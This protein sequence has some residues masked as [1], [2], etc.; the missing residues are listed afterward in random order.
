MLG[1]SEHPFARRDTMAAKLSTERGTL[2][3][4]A[5][6]DLVKSLNFLDGFIPARG[7][8][9]RSDQ[10]LTRVLAVEGQAVVYSLTPTGSVD[11]PRLDYTLM[12]AAPLS[13]EAREAALDRIR[14]FLSL[15]DDLTPL[16][17]RAAEDPVFAP[18]AR[19]LY[20]YHQVL[21]GSPFEAA[22][23][24][25]LSQR[26]L[27]TLSQRMKTALIDE[28]GARLVVDGHDYRAFPEPDILAHAAPEMLGALINHR[29]KGALLPGVAWAFA[30]MDE[31]WL[32]DAPFAE[33]AAWLK[34]I[35][36]IGEWSASFILL[37]G[38]GRVE[39]LPAQEKR[40]Q[41]VVAKRYGLVSA[42]MADVKRL[43]APYGNV[44]GYWAH[45]LRVAD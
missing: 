28:F 38:L 40:I 8:H 22:V 18:I 21:F 9:V 1:A 5:P 41:D 13:D 43:A 44:A 19:D 27:M 16:Y 35:R 23:W 6:F 11:A 30:Q 39:Q 7:E 14:F 25:I 15:D 10:T 36:G 45:Y 31:Y 37:R 42:T 12:S 24:A 20:G 3:P 33:V 29:P 26:N 32:R 4:R 2:Q 34:T 17:E